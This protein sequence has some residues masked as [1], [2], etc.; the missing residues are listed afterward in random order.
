MVVHREQA[1]QVVVVLGDRLARPVLVD[2]ADLELLV[3]ATELHAAA[4]FAARL[5][6]ILA[7][8]WHGCPQVG[9]RGAEAG[10]VSRPDAATAAAA[11]DLPTLVLPGWVQWCVRARFWL[12]ALASLAYLPVGY[13]ENGFDYTIFRNGA[14]VL[15]GLSVT[16]EAGQSGRFGVFAAEP[17][18]QV[19][20]L[21]LFATTPLAPLGRDTGRLL[22]CLL[23][24]LALP[25]FMWLLER[26]GRLLTDRTE[27]DLR[28]VVLLAGLFSVLM[29]HEL[30]MYAHIDD[31][32]CSRPPGPWGRSGGDARSSSA[33]R[34][35][36]PSTRSRGRR[37]CCHWSSHSPRPGPGCW[38]RAPRSWRSWW[39]G[40]RSSRW[41]AP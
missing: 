14:R 23:M 26:A 5:P 32:S 27:A 11:P 25:L 17:S 18:I 22:A 36:S 33:S 12:V 6:G 29:W 3:V 19:G 39:R 35:G 41:P 1:E 20:P 7:R 4:S 16:N 24:A 38:P 2:R 31:L 13:A 10:E 9:P 40:R 30:V 34:S 21:S 28:L 15:L 8:A 37:A